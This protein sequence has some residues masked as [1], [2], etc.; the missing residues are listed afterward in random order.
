MIDVFYVPLVTGIQIPFLGMLDDASVYHIARFLTGL[1][2]AEVLQVLHDFWFGIFGPPDEIMIDAQTSFLSDEFGDAMLSYGTA[3]KPIAGEAH[4]QLGKVEN[5]DA[6]LKY[7]HGRVSD[8]CPCTT[9]VEA[10]RNMTHAYSAKNVLLNRGG[11]RPAA[12]V[13]GR[14]PRAPGNLLNEPEIFFHN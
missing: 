2:A 8:Q 13:F 12:F 14:N 4:W 1:T 11:V 7:I 3:V 6:C 9:P 10:Q 5:H